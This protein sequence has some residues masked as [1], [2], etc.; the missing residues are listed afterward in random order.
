MRRTFWD[1]WL[2]VSAVSLSLVVALV[3]LTVTRRELRSLT[4]TYE[5]HL[6]AEAEQTRQL[7]ESRESLR[8]TLNSLADG[9]VA[10]DAKGRVT[11]L[12]PVAQ[13]L[14]G[15]EDASEIQG[16]PVQEILRIV[17]ESTRVEL[18]NP[19]DELLRL[20]KAPGI[21]KHLGMLDRNG[22]EFPAEIDAAPI[23]NDNREMAGAVIVFRDISQRRQT[24]QTLRVSER[25]TQAGR[26]SATIAH[27]I[28]NPLDTVT[29]LVY[30]LQ[31]DTNST[32][33]T[34]QYLQMASEELSRITQITGQLL[35]FH[36]E[37]RQPVEVSIP[38]V[39]DSVLTLYAPQI[40]KCG[41]VVEKRYETLA[42]VRGFPG[43]LRQV[44]S[45][46]VG[47]A[48]DAMPGGGRLV[49]RV[50]EGSRADD[51]TCEGVRT[52]IVDSG[53]GIA[54]GVKRNLFAP[55][56]TT[57]GDKG[58]GL[59][60]WVSRGIVEKH[61]GTIH[62]ASSVR[63]GRSGAAFS[64]FLPFEQTMGKL[65]APRVPTVSS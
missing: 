8:I 38:E 22:D 14:T 11:F 49:L 48:L 46:L 37:A 60:L 19:L 21:S 61:E 35:T 15:W 20:R 10:T 31:H 1:A 9:V 27:E 40:R 32:A 2:V 55:F 3:L 50:R 43:E 64:V 41:V 47:N 52:T 51:P 17:D 13:K 29:N 65:D 25:L 16:R 23:L 18:R 59:G 4:E 33:V 12:N 6:R 58:T 44:F 28:R 53:S 42:E 30:L 36:R 62:V 7:Q 39:L 24:E 26:L 57:K 45:N 5:M 54:L 34:Q 63:E 56:Y